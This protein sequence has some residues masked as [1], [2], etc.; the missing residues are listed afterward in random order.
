MVLVGVLV[1]VG[2]GGIGARVGC[3]AFGRRAAAR[4]LLE[5]EKPGVTKRVR[6]GVRNIIKLFIE[7]KT[8]GKD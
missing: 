3:V 6:K 7:L 8:K 4:A 2:V 5:R 1:R